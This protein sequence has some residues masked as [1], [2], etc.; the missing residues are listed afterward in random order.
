MTIF[1]TAITSAELWAVFD[2]NLSRQPSLQQNFRQCLITMFNDSAFFERTLR[3]RFREKSSMMRE[4]CICY[5]P[6][7]GYSPSIRNCYIHRPDTMRQGQ[8]KGIDLAVVWHVSPH[9]LGHPRNGNH[10]LLAPDFVTGLEVFAMRILCR[11]GFQPTG[12]QWFYN[13]CNIRRIAIVLPT[14]LGW[15]RLRLLLISESSGR[16]QGPTGVCSSRSATTE[17]VTEKATFVC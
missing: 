14:H 4:R 11:C 13:S 7:T 5:A 3:G 16:R 12:P 15:T 8:E 17:M 10:P 2:D 6:T 9:T 1:K